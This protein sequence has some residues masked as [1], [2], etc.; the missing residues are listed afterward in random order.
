MVVMLIVWCI[1]THPQERLTKPVRC[2]VPAN[3][4]FSPEALGWLKGT[5]RPPSHH[6]RAYRAG[7]LATGHDGEES[8]AQVN[9]E[10]RIP[11]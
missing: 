10:S 7:P 3:L 11:S 5:L 1:V 6:R 4:K 9:R 8:L 2:P